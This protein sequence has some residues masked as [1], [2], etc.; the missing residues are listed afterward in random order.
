[1]LD[2]ASRYK[3]V[4]IQTSSPG[5]ILLALYDGLFRFLR[6]AQVCLEQKQRA[7]A[8][9]LISKSHAIISEL[10]IALDPK[11]NPELCLHLSGVYDF[12]LDRLTQA[13]LKSDP[14]LIAEV[15]MVLSPIKEAW[16]VA[17]PQAAREQT[18]PR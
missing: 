11:H 7:R 13:N 8:G 15:I 9:E 14:M 2:V 10:L 16:E 18:L 4:Q 5:D 1:M 12:C 3:Q 17:V 6:G